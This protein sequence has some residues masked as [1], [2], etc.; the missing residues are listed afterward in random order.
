[1]ELWLLYI[2]NNFLMIVL[3]FKLEAY[4]GSV[5]H[6]PAADAYF[7][8]RLVIETVTVFFLGCFKL[9]WISMQSVLQS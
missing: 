2:T 8:P 6:H 9:T 1:M 3:N 7:M 5:S 4:H